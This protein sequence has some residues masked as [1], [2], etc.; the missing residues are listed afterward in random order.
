MSTSPRGS[1]M[2]HKQTE[3]KKSFFS[4]A[5]GK[6]TT[7]LAFIITLGGAMA[8]SESI[9]G[10]PVRPVIAAELKD[11]EE[12]IIRQ[13]TQ[14]IAPLL[15]KQTEISMR[16]LRQDERELRRERARLYEQRE[17]YRNDSNP[18]PGWLLQTISDTEQEL[19]EIRDSIQ[20][21]AERLKRIAD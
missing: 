7:A 2:S 21:E 19:D 6:A 11:L 3:V 5:M 20:D 14:S 12:T 16:V 9:I 8:A 1:N 4:S 18:I 17:G 13:Q 10:F 15:R